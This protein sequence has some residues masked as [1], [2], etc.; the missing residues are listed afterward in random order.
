MIPGLDALGANGF[1]SSSSAG[2]GPASTGGQRF[3][4]GGIQTG[5]SQGV[6][7]RMLAIAAGVVVLLGF[8]LRR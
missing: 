4:I 1:S 2:S 5:G 3:T 6:D 8:L 7:V